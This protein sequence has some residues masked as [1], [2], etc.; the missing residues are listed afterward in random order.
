MNKIIKM[1]KILITILFLLTVTAVSYAESDTEQSEQKILQEASDNSGGF[2]KPDDY[3]PIKTPGD[4]GGFF[5]DSSADNPGGRPDNGGG[6]GQ[7]APAG[8]G[9]LVLIA[10]CVGLVIVKLFY[11]YR[12]AGDKVT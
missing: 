8:D 9:L 1:R 12:F 3:S 10:C 4:Y 2:F 11:R 5:R 6:I 7:E